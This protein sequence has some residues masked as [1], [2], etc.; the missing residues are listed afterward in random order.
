[1]NWNLLDV[2]IL[3]YCDKLFF[4]NDI[5][6]V[7]GANQK[8]F[9]S[10]DYG[11]NWETIN[12]PIE[13]FHDVRNIYFYNENIGYVDGITAVYKTTEGGINW[14]KTNFP[15]TNFD[16]F[17][18]S[19]ENEGFNIETV[20]VYDGGDFP[21]FKGSICYTTDDGGAS[22][23]KSDLMKSLFLGL[24]YFPQRDLGYGF[25]LSEFCRII[26]KE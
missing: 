9:K 16:T 8:I 26:K 14:N 25:N 3:P 20:A 10:S 23:S 17:H 5:V 7:A 1:M 6:F 13:A 21:T 18:F 12:T 15:F 11:H 19:T 24:T 2:A 4:V 22:W